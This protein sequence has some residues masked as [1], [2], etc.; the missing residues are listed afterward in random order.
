MTDF[1]GREFLSISAKPIYDTDDKAIISL[2]KK[3]FPVMYGKNNSPEK[4]N[5]V[6]NVEPINIIVITLRNFLM[7]CVCVFMRSIITCNLNREYMNKLK[8]RIIEKWGEAGFQRYFSNIGWL[9]FSRILGMLIAFFVTAIVARYLGPEK[10]GTLMY[11][12]SFVG[13]FSF[14]ASLGI[15]QIMYREIIKNPEK[16]AEILGTSFILKI[17]GGFLALCITL[18]FSLFFT[19]NILEKKLIL[20]I[21]I[22]YIFQAFN[23]LNYVFQARVENKK[24]SYITITTTI[25]LSLLKLGIVFSNKGILFL[26]T[27]LVI[28]PIIYGLFFI[29]YYSKYFG[30]IRKWSF[31]VNT[32]KNII[33]ASLPLMFSSVFVIIYSRIDQVILKNYINTEAVGLYSS[34]VSLS[35]VW[36][37]IP[38]IIVSALFPSIIN[39]QKN[40][41]RTYGKRIIKLTLFLIGISSFIAIVGTVFAKPIL[42]LVFGIDFISAYKALQLYI[43]SGVGISIGTVIIQYLVAEK[44]SL[45]ILYIS[46]IGMVLNVTL[47]IIL[48]PKYGIDGAALATLVSYT[49]GPLTFLLFK[50]PRDKIIAIIKS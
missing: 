41:T 31:N 8:H 33:N 1:L 47:N 12:V 30:N 44:L 13:L 27:V 34:A 35:E 20:I 28:E 7:S 32:A 46:I 16:E 39:S 36:Y 50:A 43:W 5:G 38:T 14:L 42:N 11:A 22:S 21:S 17:I 2:I 37:F 6:N 3:A 4:I 49:V 25:I 23:I 10:Y 9:F 45:V 48:I 18:I 40:N 19:E 26:S 24:L 15:D 29:F